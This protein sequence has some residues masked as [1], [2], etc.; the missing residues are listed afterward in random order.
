M[1]ELAAWWVISR[2]VVSSILSHLSTRAA[3]THDDNRMLL[4]PKWR[5][6]RISPV[7]VNQPCAV[8]TVNAAVV[9]A[10]AI[11]VLWYLVPIENNLFKFWIFDHYL[12]VNVDRF[13]QLFDDRFSRH[14]H[15]YLCCTTLENWKFNIINFFKMSRITMPWSDK[16]IDFWIEVAFI[17]N[18][19]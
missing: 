14:C 4:R 8:D 1:T 10:S 15:M 13:L 17:K 2:R 6:C 9:D 5:K 19:R 11:Q 18:A 3:V 12:K 7:Q 16:R